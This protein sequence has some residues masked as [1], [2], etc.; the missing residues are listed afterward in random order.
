M[1][2]IIIHSTREIRK[3]DN[4][5]ITVLVKVYRIVRNQK[6]TVNCY[7][8][9]PPSRLTPLRMSEPARSSEPPLRRRNEPGVRGEVSRPL[10][11]IVGLDVGVG[12]TDE[13]GVGGI[14][15]GGGDIEP[16][17][18]ELLSTSSLAASVGGRSSTDGL[19]LGIGD[20]QGFCRESSGGSTLSSGSRTDRPSSPF[21]TSFTVLCPSDPDNMPSV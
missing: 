15:E 11:V 10:C 17:A 2:Q 21:R 9:L 12:V 6:T 8:G 13:V 16:D 5:L 7:T 14:G 1:S 20:S 4:I 19:L 18:G 3:I